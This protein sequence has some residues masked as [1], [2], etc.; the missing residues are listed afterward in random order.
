[1]ITGTFESES[2][3]ERNELFRRSLIDTLPFSKGVQMIKHLEQ[4]STRLMNGTDDSTA[5]TTERL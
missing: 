2:A 3:E 4:S 1:M 5:A